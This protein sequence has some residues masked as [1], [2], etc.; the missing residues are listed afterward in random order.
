[1]L[2]F[3]PVASRLHPP[4]AIAPDSEQ[5]MTFEG[6]LVLADPLKPGIA[7]TVIIGSARMRAKS[8]STARA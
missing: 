5:A 2:A 8:N 6:L 7:A 4:A 3:Q 1:M